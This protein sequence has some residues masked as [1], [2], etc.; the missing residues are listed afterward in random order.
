MT[1]TT[2]EWSDWVWNFLRGCRRVSPG[3]VNCYAEGVARR[4]SGPGLAY[5]GLV[6]IRDGK[7]IARWNGK[8]RILEDKLDAP[9]RKRKGLRI[10]VN[11]MSDLFY[12]EVPFEVIAAAFGIM[13]ASQRHIYQI[14]T[15]RPKRMLEFFAWL[16]RQTDRG[17]HHEPLH[18]IGVCLHYAQQYSEHEALLDTAPILRRAWPL[19]NVHVGVSIEDQ[20]RLEE[21]L[22]L[23]M[24]V[25][26][27][28]RWVSFEPALGWVDF[29]G[30]HG[31]PPTWPAL[32]PSIF[33]ASCRPN[34]ETLNAVA[35]HRRMANLARLRHVQSTVAQPSRWSTGTGY[36]DWL[37]VGGE[38]GPKARPF[39]VRMIPRLIEQFSA[40]GVPLFVKQLGS[41]PIERYG[42]LE[43]PCSG[44]GCGDGD[45]C[46]AHSARPLKL[47]HKKGAD[48]A[49][50]PEGMHVQQRAPEITREQEAEL[51]AAQEAARAA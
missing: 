8:L 43:T 51:V 32:P 31:S 18:P 7:P 28:V 42:Y 40:A 5:E 38:S 14:L 21:R 25:P 1:P 26:S 49:E 36:L 4:F 19:T 24:Q 17:P 6:Q 27:W 45:W 2:I 46:S 3:C 16:E 37:V 10:F 13:A 50:W 33:S 48:P 47:K 30:L 11:S 9:L 39:N 41:R 22:H 12:E 20:Q 15:K 34:Q 23:L 35:H 29:K 44:N